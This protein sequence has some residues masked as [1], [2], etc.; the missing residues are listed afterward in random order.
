MKEAAT[1]QLDRPADILLLGFQK[2]MDVA[3]DFTISSPCTLDQ[4]PFSPEKAKK[5]LS[6][7]EATKRQHNSEICERMRWE[8]FPVGYSTW[9]GEGPGARRLFNE[10]VQRATADLQG[11]Q[12]A[13][14]VK[15]MRQTLSLTL[16]REIARQLRLRCRVNDDDTPVGGGDGSLL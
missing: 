16:V 8:C 6:N 15:E 3:L 11:W 12:R 14:R 5:H 4:Y 7:A 10:V 13:E 2:G 1:S 9:G